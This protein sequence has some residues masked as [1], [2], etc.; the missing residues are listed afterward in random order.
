MTNVKKIAQHK[1]LSLGDI[2]CVKGIS[3]PDCQYIWLIF[4]LIISSCK[5]FWRQAVEWSLYLYK[6]PV[7]P[8]YEL[9]FD[10]TL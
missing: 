9:T 6:I 10:T 7:W 8:F 5:L 2:R 3:S 1:S 4:L